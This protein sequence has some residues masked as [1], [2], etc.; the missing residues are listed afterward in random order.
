MGTSSMVLSL[1]CG[2]GKLVGRTL[3]RLGTLQA[4]AAVLRWVVDQS[5]EDSDARQY[6][7]WTM[8]RLAR[9]DEALILYRD[10]A[11]RVPHE[12]D[13][14]VG[15]G[16]ALQKLHRHDEAIASF[17]NALERAP[18]DALIY[19]YVAASHVARGELQDAAMAYRRVLSLR[20]DDIDALGNLAATLGQLGHWEDAA[21]YAKQAFE[22]DQ[23]GIRAQNLG[24]ALAEL[25]RFSDAEKAFRSALRFN[26]QSGELRIRLAMVLVELGRLDEAIATLST[27]ADGANE[28]LRLAALSHVM[29]KAGKIDS[30]LELA[31]SAIRLN[32]QS[33][34]A[35]A[36]LGWAA[37]QAERPEE[38]YEHF[39]VAAGFAPDDVDHY[40]GQAVALSML[41]QHAS[42]VQMFE[43]V[44]EMRPDYFD[45]HAEV[46]T[47][48]RASK[49]AHSG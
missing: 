33:P 42:A 19:H 48:Y 10:L 29:L 8:S 41:G 11:A 15:L 38:A 18:S 23:N 4:A 40:A 3:G 20:P 21:T 6:L 43:K 24:V 45:D 1:A 31:R 30:A 16:E 26:E 12:A 14:Y 46:S 9:Y 2:V 22:K 39:N 17:A 35:H 44:K 32:P 34:M 28:E 36:A 37:S 7:A 5:P 47:Y 25:R 27:S 49:D 13:V